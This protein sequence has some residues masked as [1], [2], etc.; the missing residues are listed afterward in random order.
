MTR[1]EIRSRAKQRRIK[2]VARNKMM[3]LFVVTFLIV[4]GS[5]I[6]GTIFASAHAGSEESDM[7]YKYYKSIVIEEGDSLWSIASEYCDKHY[8]DTQAYID[9]LVSMNQLK[10]NKIHAGQHLVIAYYDNQFK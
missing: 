7:Q 8:T 2:E 10:S 3:I 9:E 4:L 1:E 6:Y 5:V